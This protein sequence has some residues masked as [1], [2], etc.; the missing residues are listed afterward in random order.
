[1]SAL[2]ILTDLR[3]IRQGV[4]IKNT[5]FCKNCLQ[6]FSSKRVLAELKET[7]LK[8]NGKQTVKLRSGSIKFNYY[9]KQLAVS[10]NIYADFESLLKEV[11][12]I[13][14]TH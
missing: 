14:N 6:C 12:Y 3:L 2:K 5:H 4:K 11:K 10:L 7:S 9:F 13:R 1:M 8:I